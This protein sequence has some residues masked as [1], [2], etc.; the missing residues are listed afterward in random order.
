MAQMMKKA[1]L[2]FLKEVL[3]S[4]GSHFYN[5]KVL[6]RK[7]DAALE[8]VK[9]VSSLEL[10]KVVSSHSNQRPKYKHDCPRC[11]F[12]GRNKD[13]ELGSV[14]LYHCEQAFINTP[15][16]IVRYGSEGREYVS[17]RGE[18]NSNH[19]LF[20]ARRRAVALQLKI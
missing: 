11:T 10:V 8:L 13:S 3:D 12:L 17:G 15:T 18:D 6:S 9:V 4:A 5:S 19:H 1:H 7:I 20:E 2:E 14:D 16:V